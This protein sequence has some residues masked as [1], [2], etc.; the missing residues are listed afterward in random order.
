MTLDPAADITDVY[1]FVSYDQ[2]NLDPAPADRQGDAHHERRS[3]ARS[4]A[5]AR[6]TTPS[7]TTSST[8]S[9][10]TTTGTAMRRDVIYQ[11][12]FQ[13][14]VRSP[15]PVHRHARWRP[16]AADQR[17]RRPGQRGHVARPA[18]HGDRAARLQGGREGA[19]VRVEDGALRRAAPAHGAV[20]HRPAHHAEVRPALRQQGIRT[21]AATGIRVFAGQHAE[22]FAIDLGAVFDTVNLRVE[23]AT[24]IPM[25]GRRCP[26]QTAAED[27]ND[28]VN[29]FGI[30]AFSGFNMNSI[31]IEVPISA[32]HAGR[33][34]RPT[35]R[36]A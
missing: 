4:R 13:T 14:E 12:R 8:R 26:I 11:F 34:A 32:P 9:T 17:H 19:E 21:D 36:T 22:T 30:N 24:P 31:A 3:R 15:G 18:L 10:S 29:P 1:A 25:A 35:P 33:S 28:F 27:A 6:T 5:R 23:N 16:A 2:A 20:E 7:T